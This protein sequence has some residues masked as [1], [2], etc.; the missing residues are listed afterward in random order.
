MVNFEEKEEE[1]NGASAAPLGFKAK[2]SGG[3]P[4]L[5]PSFLLPASSPPLAK[6]SHI[7]VLFFTN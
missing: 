7:Y 3:I 5:L 2:R 6:F 4:F 1:I